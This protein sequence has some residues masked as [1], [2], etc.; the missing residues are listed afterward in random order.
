M[1][2]AI[3][4]CLLGAAG[5]G[6]Y[7]ICGWTTEDTTWPNIVA[8][9]LLIAAIVLGVMVGRAHAQE[10][11]KNGAWA[12]VPQFVRDWLATQKSPGGMSCCGL[13]DAVNVKVLGDD[14]NGGLQLE[15]VN[16]RARTELHVG[17]IIVAHGNV[18]VPQNYDPNGQA[19]AWVG[20]GG[21]IVYCL[22]ELTGV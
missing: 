17:Q 19:V 13:G 12:D 5:F 1:I 3:V 7:G 11:V 14:A 8:L 16:P 6:L 9:I 15:V 10:P 4:L 2:Y 22:S 20:Y 18:Q 21:N